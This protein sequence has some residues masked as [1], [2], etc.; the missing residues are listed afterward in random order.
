MDRVNA[1]ERPYPQTSIDAM[2]RLQAHAHPDAVAA[3]QGDQV[4]TYGELAALASVQARLLSDAGVKPGDN[5]LIS[6]ERSIAEIVTTLGV[7]WA[8]RKGAQARRPS[9]IFRILPP[10]KFKCYG[11]GP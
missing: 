8:N 6:L 2:F 4:V 9:K 5:V 11:R 3:R 7:S 10:R 1:T